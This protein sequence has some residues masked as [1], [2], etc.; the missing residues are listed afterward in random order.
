MELTVEKWGDDLAV[1]LPATLVEDLDLCEGSKV[2]IEKIEQGWILKRITPL[3]KFSLSQLAEGI[4][5]ENLHQV[6]EDHPVGKEI[7]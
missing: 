4:A 6:D 5:P 3:P 2:S 7:W 1:R